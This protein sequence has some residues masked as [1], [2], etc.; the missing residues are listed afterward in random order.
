MK[1]YQE[2]LN[3]VSYI[4]ENEERSFGSLGKI[5]QRIKTVKDPKLK[6]LYEKLYQTLRED[7]YGNKNV[8]DEKRDLI[9]A[10]KRKEEEIKTSIGNFKKEELKNTKPISKEKFKVI[11]K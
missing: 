4:I 3:Q 5:L 7:I 1:T 2:F 10:I 11:R 9:N 6:E 8:D